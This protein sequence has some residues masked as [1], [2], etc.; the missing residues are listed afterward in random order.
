MTTTITTTKAG[1]LEVPGALL[2]HEVR[3]AGP[4]I[5]AIGAPMG[6]RAFTPLA[7]VLASDHT[8]LTCDPRGT[9]RSQV[10]DPEADSSPEMRAADLLH[11]IEHVN[12]GPA[13]VFGSS[14]GAV[15]ALALAQSRPDKVRRVIAH[16]PPLTELLPER[17][18]LRAG[19]Q[20]Y[21]EAYLAGD[22][23]RAW[24]AFFDQ[25]DI[26]VPADV[27]QQMF[28]GQRDPQ[29][30]ADEQFWFAHELRPTTRWRPD[31]TALHASPVAITV[32]IGE[33]SREQ[34]CDRTS[35]ALAA[36]LDIDPVIFP[37]GHTGFVD[38]PRT[39]AERLVEVLDA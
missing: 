22:V 10:V 29:E 32:G 18:A 13:T 37:G 36:T 27:V 30:V 38:T 23:V 11:V 4:L 17:E 9:G 15:T 24:T 2:Y 39:F 3:G 16:E 26:A 14:G 34:I 21:C 28:G 19:T 33:Q 31:L 1:T 12:A 20:E 6:A 35:R 8:V 7:D 5:V 25:A